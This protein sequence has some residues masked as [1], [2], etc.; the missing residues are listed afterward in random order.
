MITARIPLE[1]AVEDAF[2]EL[3]NSAEKYVKILI[4]P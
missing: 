3:L 4:H 2:K 1:N